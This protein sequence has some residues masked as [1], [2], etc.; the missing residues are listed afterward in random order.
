M[1]SSHRDAQV[2]WPRSEPSALTPGSEQ[3]EIRETIRG[4]LGRYSTIEQVRSAADSTPGYSVDL[5]KR[6]VT[7][8][9]V[10]ALAV[11]EES[12]G[13]GYGMVELG[14][15]LE[16]CGRALAVEPVYQHAAVGVRAVMEAGNSDVFEE[17]LD[18]TTVAAVS[19]LTAESDD[20]DAHR[21]GDGW[22]L[23]GQARFV[24]GGGGA[25]LIV[26]SARCPE[27]AALFAVSATSASA[28]RDRR[29][30]DSTRRQADIS[31]DGAAATLLVPTARAAEAIAR[32]Q[33]VSTLALACENTGI[34][35]ALLQMT[36]DHVKARH[37]FGR[38]IGS[39]QAI[40]HRLADMLI[41]LERARSAARYAAAVYD[42]DPEE[43]RLAIA[44]A[45]AVCS[46]AAVHA[47]HEAVQLHGGVGFTWEHSA[48]SYFRR[49]LGN[50]ALQGDSRSH[51]ARIADLLAV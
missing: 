15:I 5:W 44:V 7:D 24:V 35:D 11:P 22:V 21:I 2:P 23:S 38:P 48:H 41:E 33:D 46:D 25:D 50:E 28:V 40:K 9:S 47:A 27:G 18:G 16:E 12:G 31:F 10:T 3:A 19:A 13:L 42:E 6:L 29:V 32:I 26:V 39:F 49:V 43:A 1:T 51:R 30:V 20:L 34:A 8:M 36:L 37:Q 17:L 14:I 45:G 4:V